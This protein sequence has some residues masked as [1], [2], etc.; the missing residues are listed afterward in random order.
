MCLGFAPVTAQSLLEKVNQELP[1]DGGL[2]YATFKA[3]KILLG[4]SMETRKKG[5]LELSAISRYWNIP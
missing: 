3:T 2:T 4:H 5:T 1:E